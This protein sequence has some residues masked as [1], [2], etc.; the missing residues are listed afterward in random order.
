[1]PAKHDWRDCSSFFCTS[2]GELELRRFSPETLMGVEPT[3]S[4]FAGHCHTV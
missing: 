1:M 2:D 4:G 3:E